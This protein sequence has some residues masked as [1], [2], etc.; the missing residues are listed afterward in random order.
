MSYAVPIVSECVRTLLRG[1]TARGSRRTVRPTSVHGLILVPTRELAI[2]VS[3]E[4]ALVCKVANKYLAKC[5]ASSPPAA[6]G[7]DVAS[8]RVESF[9]VYGGVGIEP[10]VS[11]LL[12]GGTTDGSSSSHPDPSNPMLSLVVAATPGRLLDILRRGGGG[13]DIDDGRS[14]A[15]SSAFGD[16]RA[17]V[18]DEADRMACNADMTSQVDEIVSILGGARRRAGGG[19]ADDDGGGGVPSC[20]VSAT[21]PERARGACDRW[22][23]RS[24]AV[25]T[26]DSVATAATASS[27][28]NRTAREAARA[29]ATSANVRPGRETHA[30]GEDGEGPAEAS[31]SPERDAARDNPPDLSSYIPS[32]IVQTLHV[33]SNH[34]K[35]RKLILTL[36][37]ISAARGEQG[38][39]GRFSANNRLT[40]VFF[41]QIKTLKYASKLLVNEGLRCVELY[42]S[43]HQTEREKRLL[44]FKSGKFVVLAR[45]L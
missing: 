24:R 18:F 6:D 34:K 30:G 17:I 5:R 27:A 44:E 45:F 41:G 13:D 23:P 35:P 21:L 4:C 1:A 40:I 8:M 14:P 7:A 26:V 2:Q 38:K 25:V 32:N 12:G 36:Q 19:D 10:Q 3:Q 29:G 11:S 42:G 22:V 15:A 33:C 20:L 31:S 39:G 43:L 37:R 16:L 28:N 9:P